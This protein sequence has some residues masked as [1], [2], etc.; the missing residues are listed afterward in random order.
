MKE[1]SIRTALGASRMRVVRQLLTESILLALVGGLGGI[2]L[3]VWALPA[4]LA[5][6]P[7]GLQTFHHIGINP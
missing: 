5:L 1:I 4:L 6:R 3:A 7:P 2:F